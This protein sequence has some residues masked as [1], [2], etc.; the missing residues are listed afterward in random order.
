MPIARASGT[1]LLQVVLHSLDGLHPV[2]DKKDLPAALQFARN[3]LARQ[4]RLLRTH[5]GD[6]R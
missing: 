3:R 2:V 6:N 5:M 4:A 1:K